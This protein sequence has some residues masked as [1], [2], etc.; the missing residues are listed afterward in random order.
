MPDGGAPFA[1]ISLVGRSTQD[2]TIGGSSIVV[3]ANS[4]NFVQPGLVH[5]FTTNAYALIDLRAGYESPGGKWTFTI[6]GKNVFNKYY[7]NNTIVAGDYIA[8]FAGA[9]ATYGVKIAVKLR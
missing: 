5:P 8:R 9:P 7:W 6:W 2:T 4:I 1:G 3:P